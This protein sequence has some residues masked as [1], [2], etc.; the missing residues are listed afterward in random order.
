[1]E[2]IKREYCLEELKSRIPGVLTPLNKTNYI[3][4]GCNHNESNYGFI[5]SDFIIPDSFT[6]IIKDFTDVDIII[7]VDKPY[8]AVT[9]TIHVY[10]NSL[11]D[12]LS[13][14]AF[15]CYVD[16][17]VEYPSNLG[18]I[19]TKYINKNGVVYYLDENNRYF[20]PSYG[21]L[22]AD[23][24]DVLFDEYHTAVL[25]KNIYYATNNSFIKKK[26]LTGVTAKK[27]FYFFE[28][29]KSNFTKNCKGVLI[30]GNS[31]LD[32]LLF[33]IRGGDTFYKFL[34]DNFFG[35]YYIEIDNEYYPNF[36]YYSQIINEINWFAQYDGK[37]SGL[38]DC[39]IDEECCE[40][41]LYFK[42]GGHE[43]YNW[44]RNLP[45]PTRIYDLY[46]SC[47]TIPI[48]LSNKIENMGEFSIFNKEWDVNKD[49]GSGGTIT[50]Y[51]G[52]SY[53]LKDN[54]SSFNYSEEYKEK[55]FGNLN[56]D[57][58]D[59]EA[60]AY[61]PFTDKSKNNWED[62][63]E[64]Y[65]NENKIKTEKITISGNIISTLEDLSDKSKFYDENSNL[66]PGTLK[67]NG[68]SFIFPKEFESLDIRY[69]TGNVSNLKR[70][71]DVLFG[72]II[73]S[74][75]FYKYDNDGNRVYLAIDSQRTASPY[76]SVDID[77]AYDTKKDSK[78]N[79][80]SDELYVDIFYLKNAELTYY[81]TSNN[82]STNKAYS[83]TFAP[84]RLYKVSDGYVLN[85][86]TYT[87]KK[88]PFN[89]F[90]NSTNAVVVYYYDLIP[91]LTDEYDNVLTEFTL[92]YDVFSVTND[93]NGFL[94]SPS[95][96]NELY[97][98]ISSKE[99]LDTNIYI[100]RGINASF[101]KHLKLGE[102]L[103]LNDLEEYGN[104]YF[105]V[106]NLNNR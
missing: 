105:N 82:Y 53:I 16:E 81:R 37:F 7:P 62:L 52:K 102:L 97:L 32:N 55:M 35:K 4:D 45:V 54:G 98:G 85:K 95:F 17:Y 83:Y 61:Q 42:K 5:V 36:M 49:Y 99:N 96:K 1:M 43:M 66:L 2:I 57:D 64:K 28:N 51:E 84:K 76:V 101:E 91:I 70:I 22:I 75:E 67:L 56:P 21:Y 29:Y 19:P 48:Y 87:V 26:F 86:D 24:K 69:K 15:Y 14:A 71:N 41:V 9:H 89:Y 104:G 78:N 25:M 94:Y 13:G 10:S 46:T 79:L 106:I 27:W 92:K 100:D 34:C 38:S 44:M 90:I 31:E 18:G 77:T 72:D 103:T 58:Y 80:L 30:N 88:K 47:L 68:N 74:I 33:Q 65:I 63:T 12:E 8:T 40:C 73:V 59:D 39:D 3:P 11:R 6:D 20:D 23:V 60:N 50:L 93:Y